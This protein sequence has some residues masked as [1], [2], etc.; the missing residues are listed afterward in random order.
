LKTA[1]L[2]TCCL[3]FLPLSGTLR[4]S[5]PRVRAPSLDASSQRSET[6]ARLR[7]QLRR[8]GDAFRAGDYERA[9]GIARNGFQGSLTAREPA[10][11]AQFLGNV[12]GVQF[13]RHQFENSLRT[14][15]RAHELALGAGDHSTAAALTANIASLYSEL[16]E[17]DA[18]AEWLERSA[19][20]LAGAE[21]AAHLPKVEV[22]LATIRARQNRLED[23]M[24]LFARAIDAADRAGDLPLYA[25][26]WSRI[27]EEYLRRGDL[28]RA[29]PALLESF[30]IRK[31]HR[32]P[33]D[34]SYLNLGKLRLEQGDLQAAGVLL[35]RAEELARLPRGLMPTWDIYLARGRVRQAQ[36]GLEEA[37]ADF[38]IAV[39]LARAWRWSA[40]PDDATRIGTEGILQQVYSALADAGNRLYLR[41]RDPRLLAETL[42]AAEENRAASLRA[43]L[44]GPRR[45]VELP[46]AYW[47]A[48]G[49][50]QQAEVEALRRGDAAGESAVRDARAEVVRLTAGQGPEARPERPGALRQAR[51]SLDSGT[52]VLVFQLGAAGSWLWAVDAAGMAL[53]PLAP[54][55]EIA[56]AVDSW[57]RDTR[58]DAPGAAAGGE[59]L[60]SLLFGKLEERFRRKPRWLVALD[61]GLFRA[62]LATLPDGLA[63]HR[64]YLAES[65]SLQVIPALAMLGEAAPARTD[66]GWFVGVGDPI[67][68]T[69]D[70]RYPR[71]PAAS[72]PAPSSLLAS[73]GPSGA[74]PLPRLVSSRAEI[75][76]CARAWDGAGTLLL[77]GAEASTAR[78]REALWREP[79]V[80]HIAAH[81]AQSAQPAGY[82]V[83]VLSL[84][85]DGATDVITPFEVARWRMPG[86]LVVL[87]GC[88]SA[89]GASLPG[90]GLLGLTRAW[91]AAGAGHVVASH[92]A[93][94]DDSGALFLS[95]YRHLRNAPQAGV[96]VALQQA[97]RD[98]IA[99]GGWRS[100]PRYWGAYFVIGGP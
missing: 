92:W 87:S 42:E 20:G 43:I 40:P 21:G 12:G 27:G 36:G 82:G 7:V 19:A 39:R 28:V 64:P 13:A 73:S 45:R 72:G 23:A 51:R 35:D 37:L 75:E 58:A 68:N 66:A 83:T 61:A 63:E 11:A 65:H 89:A 38:R 71:L 67:Y 22:Q 93:T 50:L 79:A 15:L 1:L 76:A 46:P 14:Y 17:L 77:T 18:A 97:Q 86:G 55:G 4:L 54:A 29:E 8:S 49:R 100:E 57:S 60:Y 6:R 56:A 81:V 25:V 96:A 52:A 16:G 99:G 74:L 69:A 88:A 10:L 26:A 70:P 30:R 9:T 78:V 2:L 90:T 91:L 44:A 59:R 98:M 47:A 84:G 34:G 32:L 80:L 53:Y 48:I 5:G 33:L 3:L 85:S 62:P 24:A 94:P 41:T 31:L 95:F